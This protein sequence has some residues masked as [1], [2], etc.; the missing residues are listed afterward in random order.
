MLRVDD[1]W[2][3]HTAG[4]P[5]GTVQACTACGEVLEDN[6]AWLE[7]RVAVPVEQDG[8]GPMWWPVGERIAMLGNCTVTLPERPLESD[9]RLCAGAN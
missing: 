9:E 2:I 4:T 6:T 1:P 8:R 7:G 5:V 3:V